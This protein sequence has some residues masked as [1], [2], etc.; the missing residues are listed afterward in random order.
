MIILTGGA[1][2]IG[3]CFLSKLNENGENDVIIIDNLGE[4]NKWK[5]LSGKSFFDYIAKDEFIENLNKFKPHKKIKAIFHIGACS[6]TTE[7]DASYLIKNNYEYSKKLLIWALENNIPFYYASSAATYG[8]GRS[9]YSDSD[10]N[11]LALLPLNMYGYSKH[12]FD[13]WVIKN[14]LSDKI[15]GFKYFN[16]FGPN[17]YH[18]GDMRSLVVKAYQQIKK[19][20][21]IK[22]FKSYNPAYKDGEQK[23][24]FIYIKDV[25]EL[26]Y[27]FY[28]K[29]T[30]KGI[31]NV[32]TGKARTWN[33]LAKAIFSALGISPDI[34]YIEM[35]EAIKDKYQYFTQADTSKL[36]SSNINIAFTS[37]ENSVADYVGN[38]LEKGFSCI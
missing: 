16:V 8:D 22:L 29:T 32:G 30:V 21:K 19:D 20:G 31:Y 13:L 23:R 28:S 35:P 6:C 26:M 37:L 11:T 10:E 15:V 3:S 2:F 33:D 7:T 34:E 36:R 25:V 17:E 9:G 5:N 27:Y 1:G 38:Y 18:K 4:D 12:L 24:D 14:K